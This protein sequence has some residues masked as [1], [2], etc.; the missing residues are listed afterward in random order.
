MSRDEKE[1]LEIIRDH[2][3]EIGEFV[4]SSGKK[5]SYYLDCR[6]TTLHPRGA[7]LSGRLILQAIRRHGIAPEAIGGLTLGA[8]PVVTAVAVMSAVDGT[9]LPAFIVRKEAKAHGARRRI[10]GWRG[11][12]G[13]RVLIADD[14]CTSGGSILE[15]CRAAESEGYEVAATMCI[16][17]RLD[18][19]AARLKDSYPF[20]SLFT[21]RDLIPDQ[22]GPAR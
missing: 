7:M 9:P 11:T 2:S 6:V 14:V 20:F 5:S 22:P 13:A 3:L 18:P 15:A 16:V 17:D 12:S 8:D 1:L 10:E 19:S 4:L 21:V